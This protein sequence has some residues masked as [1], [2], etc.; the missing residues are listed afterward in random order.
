VSKTPGRLSSFGLTRPASS[1]PDPV[2]SRAPTQPPSPG[3]LLRRRGR[4]QTTGGS[5]RV[6]HS[7]RYQGVSPF[8]QSRSER[9]FWRQ[10]EEECKGKRICQFSFLFIFLCFQEP[11]C[12]SYSRFPWQNYLLLYFYVLFNSSKVIETKK[13]SANKNLR[14]FRLLMKDGDRLTFKIMR[15]VSINFRDMHISTVMS[16]MLLHL[17]MLDKC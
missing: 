2:S 17:K 6:K 5:W 7:G 1:L 12:L 14:I 4:V 8:H 16:Y 10:R 11:F 9:H 13:G 3:V 15:N